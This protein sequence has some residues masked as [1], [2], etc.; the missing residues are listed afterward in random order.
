MKSEA[1][2]LPQ[3]LPRLREELQRLRLNDKH[4]AQLVDTFDGL[5][6]RVERIENGLERLDDIALGRLKRARLQSRDELASQFRRATGQC[7]GCGQGCS[8]R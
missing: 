5:D 6:A 2:P 3:E 8:G 1:S 7:C 4:F